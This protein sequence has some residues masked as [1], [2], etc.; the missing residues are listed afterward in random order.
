MCTV[1]YMAGS[2]Y[3]ASRIG[4]INLPIGFAQVTAKRKVQSLQGFDMRK[5]YLSAC[6]RSE[7]LRH[8]Y[9][10]QPVFVASTILGIQLVID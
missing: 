9:V 1:R 2:D 10:P 3:G 5:L 6:Y 8:W 4:L 7:D